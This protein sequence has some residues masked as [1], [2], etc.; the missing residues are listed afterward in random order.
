MVVA[1]FLWLYRYATGSD[2]SAQEVKM[3][4]RLAQAEVSHA[5]R[6]W[7]LRWKRAGQY[8]KWVMLKCNPDSRNSHR[9]KWVKHTGSDDS[10]C[11]WFP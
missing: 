1:S 11:R 3:V 4:S 6:K 8:R 2:D 5:H 9:R 7:W 10:C